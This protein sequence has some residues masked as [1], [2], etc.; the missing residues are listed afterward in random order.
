MYWYHK[1]FQ[2]QKTVVCP[3]FWESG[4]RSIETRRCIVCPV[5][6]MGRSASSWSTPQPA[7]AN[8]SDAVSAFQYKDDP[9]GKRFVCQYGCQGLGALPVF[10][11]KDALQVL[12]KHRVTDH[13]DHAGPFHQDVPGPVGIFLRQHLEQQAG[14]GNP[15]PV[16]VKQVLDNRCQVSV[17]F[18]LVAGR[19]GQDGGFPF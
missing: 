15:V 2:P 18:S 5:L 12:V 16:P 19:H 13:P 1:F 10:H 9:A 6:R 14:F 8:A 11:M 17:R 4:N 3:S 7:L